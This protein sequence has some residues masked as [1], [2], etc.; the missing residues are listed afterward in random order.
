MRDDLGKL[1]IDPASKRL[2]RKRGLSAMTNTHTWDQM[3]ANI[4]N[5]GSQGPL[6]ITDKGQTLMKQALKKA[7][8]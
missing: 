1:P 2:A 7:Q 5:H 4:L 6:K 8:T 3:T